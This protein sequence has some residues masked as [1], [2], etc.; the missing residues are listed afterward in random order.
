MTRKTIEI[1][2]ARAMNLDRFLVVPNMES[3]IVNLSSSYKKN[4][5][6]PSSELH[7]P[8]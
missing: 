1:G 4:T 7:K 2:Y 5:I 6:D 3:Q 8:F